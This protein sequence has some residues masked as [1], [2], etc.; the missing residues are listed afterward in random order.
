MEFPISASPMLP[1]ARPPAAPLQKLAETPYVSE[2]YDGG[3]DRDRTCGISGGQAIVAG[4][5]SASGGGFAGSD[6][7]SAQ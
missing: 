2:R 3:R 5:V 1:R 7:D 4:V 6:S